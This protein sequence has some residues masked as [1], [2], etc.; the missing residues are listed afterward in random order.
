MRT[1]VGSWSFGCL[2][3]GLVLGCA[4]EEGAAQDRPEP[5]PP[6]QQAPADAEPTTR[7]TAKKDKKEA[8]PR[9]YVATVR[10]KVRRAGGDATPA[11]PFSVQG[12]VLFVPEVSL[13]GGGSGE[14]VKILELQRGSATVT[15]PFHR[16]EKLVVGESPKTQEDRLQLTVHL[17]DVEG[18]QKTL[19]GTVKASLE[20]RGK[21]G[22]TDLTTAVRLRD[23]AEVQFS[24]HEE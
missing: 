4:S 10:D 13:F 14:E 15:I 23:T 2:V 9:T 8:D 20:L 7:K 21:L 19:P 11:K 1:K 12:A 5:T 22:G 3:L 16:I 24:I 18:D 17:R 6:P